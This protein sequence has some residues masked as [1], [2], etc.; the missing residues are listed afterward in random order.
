MS[1]R[2][3]YLIDDKLDHQVKRF[4]E[5]CDR[6]LYEENQRKYFDKKDRK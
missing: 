5:R 6:I 2:E 1:D 4:I 3:Y